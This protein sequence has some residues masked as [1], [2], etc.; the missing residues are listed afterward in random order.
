M[1]EVVVIEVK[2]CDNTDRNI[3][4]VERDHRICNGRISSWTRT[5]ILTT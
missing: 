5:G 4:Y 1:D 3:D 2:Q